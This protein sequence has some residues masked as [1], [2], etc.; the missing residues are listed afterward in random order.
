MSAIAWYFVGVASMMFI[1]L[2][3]GLVVR[4]RI[5]RELA[6]AVARGLDP[7]EDHK[8]IDRYLRDAWKRQTS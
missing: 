4:R 8:M 7:Y 1:D 6:E 5:R 2:V 3:S